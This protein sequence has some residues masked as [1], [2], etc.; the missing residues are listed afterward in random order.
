MIANTVWWWKF[1]KLLHISGVFGFLGAHGVS[2]AVAL[3]LR[4]ERDPVRVRALL[5]VS[6]STRRFMYLSLLLLLVAGISNGFVLHLWGQGWIWTALGL[7]VVLLG[8]AVP[9]TV[10]YYKKV[11]LAVAP[12]RASMPEEQLA[13]LLSSSRPIAIAVIE[14]AG[15]LVIA[16]LM[17]W[18]PF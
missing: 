17:V 3:Q 8:V 15:I 12:E 11:R 18:K 9:L 6:A 14:T 2:A 16:W 1:W 10:P 4:K 13:A 5:E 7:L